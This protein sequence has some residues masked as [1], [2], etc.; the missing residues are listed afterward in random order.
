MP[1]L[2]KAGGGVRGVVNALGKGKVNYNEPFAPEGTGK[3]ES[4]RRSNDQVILE[5]WQKL[6][7]LIKG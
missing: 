2:D 1:Q 5:R 7:G 6:A 4:R 3:N